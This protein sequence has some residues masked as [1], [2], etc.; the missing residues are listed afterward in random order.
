MDSL[1][2]QEVVRR[3][4]ELFGVSLLDQQAE[5]AIARL[6]EMVAFLDQFDNLELDGVPLAAV[7]DP[8]WNA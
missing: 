1:G 4:S 2:P 6:A 3:I 8:S 5:D 7:Y